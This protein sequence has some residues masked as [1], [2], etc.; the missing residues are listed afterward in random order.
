MKKIVIHI[1]IHGFKD[2]SNTFNSV[3]A[4][5]DGGSQLDSY[6]AI[7]LKEMAE[8]T[9]RKVKEYYLKHRTLPT[10]VFFTFSPIYD[11]RIFEDGKAIYY[12]SLSKGQQEELWKHYHG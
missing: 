3:H 1:R 6:T 10:Q 4:L 2:P 5:A 11:S 12:E 8:T 9:R 7:G